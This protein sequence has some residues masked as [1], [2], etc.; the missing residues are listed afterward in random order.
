[1][2]PVVL[3]VS[4]ILVAH[5]I[6]NRGSLI[7]LNDLFIFQFATL[8]LWA[9]LVRSWAAD[10]RHG[11]SDVRDWVIPVLGFA[12][13]TSTIRHGWRKWTRVFLLI[14]VLGAFVGIYQ[15]V[16]NN[17]RPFVTN[18]ASYKMGFDLSPDDN[19]LALASYAVGFFTHPNGFAI[20]LFIGLMMTLGWLAKPGGRWLK[21]VVLGVI[22][23]ALFWT[24]AKASLLA[25]GFG[26]ILFALQHWIKR[27]KYFLV[28]VVTLV[29]TGSVGFWLV[30]QYFPTQ[31]LGT[32][33][34]RVGLWQTALSTIGENPSILFTGNG[35]DTFA[36]QAYYGQPHNVYL[37][38]VLEYGLPGLTLILTALWQVW[39]RGWHVRMTLMTREP[40]LAALWIALLSYFLIGLVE[41]NLFGIENRMIFLACLACFVGL[42]RELR[43]EVSIHEI[44]KEDRQYAGAPVAHP[45]PV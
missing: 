14:V 32:F 39:K 2:E 25:V 13:L 1:L 30:A 21:M 26:V 17:F 18:L 23:L 22:V 19:Q 16:C 20:Y 8:T 4:V 43:T 15:H 11:M 31:L 38:I 6:Q 37:Y 33:W 44:I 24:Y 36:N 12:V 40:M 3:I 35:L 34:W 41:S 45:R 28:A 9:V 27:S 29:T 7:V 5:Q 10:W 42:Y